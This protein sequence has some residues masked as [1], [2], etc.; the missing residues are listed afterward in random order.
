MWSIAFWL[1]LS[2]SALAETVLSLAQWGWL[3]RIERH[4]PPA[5]A[6]LL[7]EGY[8]W[9]R[10]VSYARERLQV[11]LG[12]LM[13]R[14]AGIALLVGTG[15]LA[16]ASTTAG[17]FFPGPF[18]SGFVLGAA[19][20]VAGSLLA[21]PWDYHETFGVES[22]FGFNRSSVGLFFRDAALQCLIASG[23]A[24]FLA[25]GAS[26]LL[27]RP[28]GAAWAIAGIMVFDLV[29]V[30]LFPHV[31]LPIF[32]RLRPLPEGDLKDALEALFE[33]TGFPPSAL[34]VADGSR[35]SSHGNAFFAGFGRFRRVILF[36]TLLDTFPVPEAVAVVAHEIGHWKGRHV[37]RGLVVL[38]V[39][40]A[41]FVLFAFL[42]WGADSFPAAFGL[43]RSPA[44]VV[45]MAF[46]FWEALSGLL[47]Q[48]L[49]SAGSRRRE[50]EADNYAA[51]FSRPDPMISA[52]ARLGTDSLAWTPSHPWFSAWYATHP[53]VADR[54]L[55]LR[56][57]EGLTGK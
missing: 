21:L 57:K 16:F 27:L 35:R 10:G 48:P 52:L 25:G 3:N 33:R 46:L 12:S 51:R 47:L 32:Y 42:A 4:V 54:I 19:G 8:G 41:S 23:I 9:W 38:F 30:F 5:L 29:L 11:H 39:V 17:A 15:A 13:T 45:I 49:V 22:R 31:V 18:A 1:T 14:Y 20:A 28:L 37:A 34:M 43:D 53:S 56:G 36:D 7:P 40:Q 26:V 6:P 2:V 44:I 55:A 24:G 50:F